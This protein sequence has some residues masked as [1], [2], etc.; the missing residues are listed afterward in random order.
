[1]NGAT[2]KTVNGIFDLNGN[3]SEWTG[4]LRTVFGEIQV[5]PNNNGADSSNPQTAGAGT[6]KNRCHF[7]PVCRP[8]RNRN[9]Y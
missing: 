8:G 5:Q 7:R 9:N 1:M 6:W 2:T 3:V 4:G